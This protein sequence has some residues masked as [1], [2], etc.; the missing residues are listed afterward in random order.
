MRN[1]TQLLISLFWHSQETSLKPTIARKALQWTPLDDTSYSEQ[2]NTTLHARDEYDCD[3]DNPCGNGACCGG[4]G[5]C[6]YGPTYCG[7]DC[8]SNCDA[9]AEC[10]KY[11]KNPGTTC[12]LNTCCSEFG[13][14]GTT[15]DFCKSTNTENDVY[16]QHL[17]QLLTNTSQLAAKA[18][19]Y[20][21][22]SH[23]VGDPLDP[24]WETELSVIMR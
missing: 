11:A 20:W 18:T 12:P 1:P 22:P 3:A 10:G 5:Y 19:A 6:G 24:C 2:P 16:L 8:V 14:C 23:L 15:S 21:S 4:S 17:K 7:T 9:V 13:F